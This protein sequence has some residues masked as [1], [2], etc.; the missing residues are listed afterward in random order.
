MEG[1]TRSDVNYPAAAQDNLE[2]LEAARDQDGKPFRVVD[3]PMPRPLILRIGQRLTRQLRQFLHRQRPRPRPDVQR[4][5][6][7]RSRS[8]ILA[9]LFA[10]REV[11]GIHSGDLVWGLGH[12]ALHDSATTRPR[13]DPARGGRLTA[14]TRAPG[15]CQCT[16]LESEI[17][18]FAVA[19]QKICQLPQWLSNGVRENPGWGTPDFCGKKRT[20]SPREFCPNAPGLA[21]IKAN[22]QASEANFAGR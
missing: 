3:L 14:R 1:R 2:R 18:D 13:V 8:T 15:R 17:V 7:P 6:R 22:T 12:P 5:R 16:Q 10:D 9:G 21:R 20:D 11:I 4:P 19:P